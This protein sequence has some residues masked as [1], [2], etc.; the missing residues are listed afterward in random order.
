MISIKDI[1]NLKINKMDKQIRF[2]AF[3]QSEGNNIARKRYNFF[4]TIKSIKYD[5]YSQHIRSIVK[6]KHNQREYF[7][8]PV[9]N[10]HLIP[11]C[12]DNE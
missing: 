1:K 5:A 7:N 3:L 10:Y 11:V 4:K 12:D 2:L 6:R 8:Y 9:T